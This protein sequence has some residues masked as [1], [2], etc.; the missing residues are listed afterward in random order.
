MTCRSDK[1]GR[2]RALFLAAMLLAFLAAIVAR[3][4]QLQLLEGQ[5]FYGAAQKQRKRSLP[6]I[7]NRGNIYS[8]NLKELALTLQVESLYA[9]PKELADRKAAAKSLARLVS[10]DQELIAERLS[11]G[12]SFVW[13]KRWMD[14]EKAQQIRDQFGQGIDFVKEG[15]RFYPL[16]RSAGQLLGFVGLD[17]KGLEGLEL[18]YDRII[19]GT[20]G[21][22]LAERDARGRFMLP[23]GP[24]VA[25]R[26]RSQNLVL[27]LD[28]NIQYLAEKGLA[29]GVSAA[30]AKRGN[31]IVLAPA[32]GEIL[33]LANWPTFDPNYFW[34][35]RPEQW[36]NM[37][38]SDMFEPGSTMKIFTVAAALEEKILKPTDLIYTENGLFRIGRRVIHDVHPHGWLSLEEVI[39]VSSNI[40]AAKVGLRLGRAR[41]YRH[42]KGFGFFAPTGVD[43]RGEESGLHQPLKVWSNIAVANISFGQGI[44]LTPL[45]LA[46]GYAALANGGYLMKP[47]LLKQVVDENG[48]VI[49]E[50]RPQVIRKVISTETS[51]QARRMLMGVIGAEGT[52]RQAEVN[53]YAVAGK[54]G[55]AQKASTHYRGYA[56]GKYVSSFVGWVPAEKPQLLIL[57]VIDEPKGVKYGG[58]V[59][60]PVFKEIAAQALAYLRVSPDRF[61]KA[62][63]TRKEENRLPVSRYVPDL[64]LFLNDGKGLITMPDFHGLALRQVLELAANK[65]I[66]IKTQGS[67]IAVWQEPAGGSLVGVGRVGLVKL[68][69]AS[70]IKLEQKN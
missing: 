23:A 55:T 36:R 68:S 61:D 62:M 41:L 59:A 15:R 31:V 5:R 39:K 65:G 47:Y 52:G 51:Q 64:S 34:K 3:G 32:S 58:V 70:R 67:G 44:A 57:V 28:E 17:G 43:L 7:S 29:R 11:N 1:K 13:I 27:T 35:Y 25:G 42:L 9:I 12:R 19:R 63:V 53:G 22:L 24:K 20:P 18:A 26:T 6:L 14:R 60:A 33:A 2:G 45:Q 40:G 69:P 37:A 49:K 38:I 48:R 54:T 10:V 56:P 30:Q 21:N 8:R 50:N 46:L 66:R 4:V 16:G